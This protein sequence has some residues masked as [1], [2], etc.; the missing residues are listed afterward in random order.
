MTVLAVLGYLAA[1]I[2]AVITIQK[3]APVS[4][5]RDRIQRA[6][7]DRRK[8]RQLAKE[9]GSFAPEPALIDVYDRII[10]LAT[11]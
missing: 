9:V 3:T 1:I 11:P 6:I 5:Q 8:Q 7:R 4:R 10:E 2:G